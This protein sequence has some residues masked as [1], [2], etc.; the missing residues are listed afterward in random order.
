MWAHT[1]TRSW[2]DS[3]GQVIGPWQTTLPATAHNTHKRKIPMPR[4]KVRTHNPS[5]RAATWKGLKRNSTEYASCA[6]EIFVKMAWCKEKPTVLCI[7]ERR[8]VKA[9]KTV[10]TLQLLPNRMKRIRNAKRFTYTLSPETS[11]EESRERS[12]L[13]KSKQNWRMPTE[14]V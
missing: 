4:A 2:Y 14:R 1:I 8:I 6:Q 12:K 13:R 5:A 10:Y 11:V 9:R 7:E 3:P